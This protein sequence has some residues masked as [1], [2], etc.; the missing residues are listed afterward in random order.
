ML[1]S[2]YTVEAA[3]ICQITAFAVHPFDF[4]KVSSKRTRRRRRF[5]TDRI[6]LHR[7][8]IQRMVYPCYL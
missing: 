3:L 1:A 8:G 2:S 6:A 5:Q 7:R 4:R